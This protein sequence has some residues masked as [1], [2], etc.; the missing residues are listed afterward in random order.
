MLQRGCIDGEV[1]STSPH[2]H[3][4]AAS[5]G[6]SICID[7]ES[8]YGSARFASTGFNG[9]VDLH[10]PRATS[11]VRCPSSRT[12]C[13]NGAV[14]LHRRRA[15]ECQRSCRSATCFNGAVDLHRRR[16][17]H[18]F[19]VQPRYAA[20]TGPSICIDGEASNGPSRTSRGRCFNGA[21][22]LHR[23][24]VEPA[25]TPSWTSSRFNGAVD[26]HRRRARRGRLEDPRVHRAS[27][28]P[29]I[30]IDGELATEYVYARGNMLLQRGRRSGSTE[31]RRR[32]SW[33]S[34]R[35]SSF[36]GAV[37][38]H[39]RRGRRTR[40]DSWSHDG[41]NGA[42]DLHRRRASDPG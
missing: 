19:G 14:D 21:V 12:P 20:S 35:R 39:R 38:L 26:L 11:S 10:R 13:F 28:G 23:R 6:P 30:C 37:D 29:S 32:C 15:G 2:T 41:F 4:F 5:T 16:V 9:A 34:R 7:G 3:L 17:A 8:P 42:V 31:S 18:A 22:D 27:T 24:R 1:Q 33:S 40:R 25:T 36:N